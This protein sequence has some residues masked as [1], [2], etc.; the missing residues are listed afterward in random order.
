M[1]HKIGIIQSRGAGDIVILAPVAQWYHDR[2]AEIHWMVDDLYYDGF[3]YAF[4]DFHWHKISPE[5]EQSLAANIKNP[6]WYEEPKRILTEIGVDEI[7]VF[8]YEEIKHSVL[9]PDLSTRIIDPITINARNSRLPYMKSFDQF[10]YAATNVPFL[11]KWKLKLKR[12]EE[13]EQE[14]YDKIV[15][16][17]GKPYAV[18][19]LS[20]QMGR[21][22]LSLGSDDQRNEFLKKACKIQ[23]EFQIIDISE[24]TNN[25][26]DWL[27]VL[28]NAKAFIGI[29]S[30]F[31]NLI[32]QLMLPIEY[33]FFIRR[34]TLDFTPVLGTVWNYI[35][36]NLP[37]DKKQSELAYYG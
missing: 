26:L 21:V 14:L 15:N 23:D 19:N 3:S 25:P 6:Y 34:S 4:P 7:F 16:K 12:N 2:G 1:P 27:K 8:L 37:S 5:T 29:D 10:K 24:I 9:L 30:F 31:V 33:K 36:I 13:K 32:D 17:D 22:E 35:P 28:E 20:V 11:Q 18:F